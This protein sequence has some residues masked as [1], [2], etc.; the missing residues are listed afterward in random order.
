[1]SLAESGRAAGAERLQGFDTRE[2]LSACQDLRREAEEDSGGD[3]IDGALSASVMLALFALLLIAAIVLFRD[4]M[5]VRAAGVSVER[6]SRQ[7]TSAMDH[8]AASDMTIVLL[9]VEERAAENVATGPGL[10]R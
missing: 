9:G 2:V 7:E 3:V 5:D 10:R 8:D 1:M 4:G 6:S